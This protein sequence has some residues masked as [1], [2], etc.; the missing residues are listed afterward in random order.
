MKQLYSDVLIIGAGLSGLISAFA[1]SHLDQNIIIVDKF[2]FL[3]KKES[4]TDLRTTAIAEGSKDFLKK[5]KIWQ[6]ISVYAEPIKKINVFD[7]SRER[8]IKFQNSLRDKNLGYIIK[9][10]K[11]K[12]SVLKKLKKLNNI[13]FVTSAKLLSIDNNSNFVEAKFDK[14]SINSKLLIA[15]DGKNSTVRKLLKTKQFNKNYNHNAVVIN[16]SHSKDHR[17]IAHELFYN[18]GP[19]AILPMKKI[20]KNFYSSSVI[21]S[22]NDKNFP[23][24]IHNE[25]IFLKE[26]LQEKIHKYVGVIEKINGIQTFPLSAHINHSFYE[27]K[28]V[29][30]GDSAHSIHPIAGQG[31]NLGVRDIANCLSSFVEN[32]KLGLEVGS[33]FFCKNYNDKSYYDSFSLF[34]ITDKLNS[35]FMC[36]DFISNS[37]RK[38]GFKII[39]DNKKIK[40]YITNFAMGI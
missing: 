1:L 19:L 18:S 24:F 36:D 13:K 22:N 14:L 33:S 5:I 26:L 8:K 32:K 6:N 38:T 10:S 37:L 21:W 35:I 16:F 2:D 17:N 9:N 29:Y 39:E 31:W 15:A 28:T 27:E 25:N 7:R 30:I 20:N 4:K 3:S 34:Q 11:I 40:N 12:E 23:K